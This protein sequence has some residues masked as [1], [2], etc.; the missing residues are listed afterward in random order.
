M[1]S[2]HQFVNTYRSPIGTGLVISQDK[3]GEKIALAITEIQDVIS[4]MEGTDGEGESIVQQ[5]KDEIAEGSAD[6]FPAATAT[7]QVL[8]WNGTAWVADFVRATI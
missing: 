8:T 2:G 3:P 6:V 5:V 1:A 7:W 4:N